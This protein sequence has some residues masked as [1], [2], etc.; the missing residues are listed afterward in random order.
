MQSR[1]LKER[2]IGLN[3][4]ETELCMKTDLAYSNTE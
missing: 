1:M 3:F 4:F 2:V